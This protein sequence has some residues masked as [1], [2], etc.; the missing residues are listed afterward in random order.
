MFKRRVVVSEAKYIDDIVPR[1]GKRIVTV[2]EAGRLGGLETLR[3]HGRQHF[4]A[5]GCRGQEVIAHCYTA[6]D[7]RRWG[8]L[9]GRPRKP[10][11]ADVGEK[12]Q[13]R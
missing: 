13:S 2:S 1:T 12:G 7:R 4:V 9:G 3:R 5:A 10:R 6:E 8:R 11:L